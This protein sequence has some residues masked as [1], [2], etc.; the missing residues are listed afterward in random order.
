[1]S[2]EKEKSLLESILKRFLKYNYR[3]CPGND[4]FSNSVK[5][6]KTLK[7]IHKNVYS[8]LLLVM[9]ISLFASCQ[10]DQTSK[11]CEQPFVHHVFFWLNNPDD[12][13]D[14]AEF[15]KGVE[16]LLEVPQIKSYHFGEPAATTHRDVVDGS[17]TYSYMVFFE[18]KESQDIYQ[19]HPIHQKFI[20]EYQHLWKKVQVYDAVMK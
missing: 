2:D 10:N 15:E 18:D 7:M 11:S 12:P 19:E 20:D 14:R 6:T 8:A 5:L 1:M 3:N 9:V 13:N 4:Y 16:E 17:Y